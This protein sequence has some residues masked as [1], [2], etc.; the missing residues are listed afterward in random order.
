LHSEK[1]P[2]G[3]TM[4]LQELH[5]YSE[6]AHVKGQ[7]GIGL[8]TAIVAVLLAIATMLANRTHVEGGKLEARIEDLWIRLITA[9]TD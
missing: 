1:D 5:S 2:V 9:N 3:E 4:D 7:K 6:H 8:T